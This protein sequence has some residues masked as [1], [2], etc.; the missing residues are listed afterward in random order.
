MI[1]TELRNPVTTVVVVSAS[2]DA[3]HHHVTDEL[4]GRL[5]ETGHRPDVVD[6]L[7][8]LPRRVGRVVRGRRAAALRG[9]EAALLGQLAARRLS[10]ILSDDVALA[11]STHPLATRALARCRA[12]RRPGPPFVV[13]L[14]DPSVRRTSVS[15][16]AA[17]TVAPTDTAARQA[18]RHGS[19]HT[20]VLPPP[21]T[22]AF[23]PAAGPAEREGLRVALRL[24]VRLRLALVV[25]GTWSARQLERTVVD[26][27]ATGLATPVVLCGRRAALRDRLIAAGHR[28]VLGPPRDERR[29]EHPRS[30]TDAGRPRSPAIRHSSR[31]H[32]ASAA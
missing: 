17:L 21:V 9:T 25:A 11:V 3:G 27:V 30:S 29:R 12:R 20:V 22:A 23:R 32:A 8:L 16:Y 13:Q 31:S 10:A 28:N 26:V 6:A 7:D 15:R 4:V 5:Q 18:R 24:P 1:P 14:S 19:G 2:V